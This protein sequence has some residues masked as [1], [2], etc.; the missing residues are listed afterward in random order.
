MGG[1]KETPRQ[2]M[3]GMMYL[4]LTALLALNVS[5]EVLEAFGNI[6][7][8]LDETIKVS[9]VK[10]ADLYT[11]ISQRVSSAGDD[12]NAKLVGEKMVQVKAIAKELDEHLD[13]LKK[14]MVETDANQ[15][16]DQYLKGTDEY[17]A[18]H[19]ENQKNIDVPTRLLVEKG[20]KPQN[21]GEILMEKINTT[22]K[23]LVDLFDGLSITTPAFKEDLDNRLTLK[24][25]DYPD[26]TEVA[27]KDWEYK[28]FNGIPCGAAIALLTKYQNDLKNAESEVLKTMLEAISAGKMEIKDFVPVV[29]VR[30][31]ALAVG[32]KLEAE[33]FLAAQIGG[34][35]PV[36]SVNGKEIEVDPLT[37]RGAYT[38]MAD[39]QGSKSLPVN[40]SVKNTKT[41][42]TKPYETVLE[43]DVFKAPAIISADKMNVVYQGLDNPISISVP[44][45][46]PSQISASMSPASVGELVK[47]S[48]GK[49]VAKIKGR[50]RNGVNINVSVKMPD[51]STKS[52]GSQNFRTLKVPSPTASLNGNQG[53]NMSTGALQAVKVVSVTLE[54]FVFE[55][56]RYKVVGF[57][58][59]YRPAR[60]NLIK[61][62]ENSQ[63][64]P[65]Q[66]RAA[67]SNAKRGDLL[68]ISGIYASAPGLGKVPLAGSLVFNV[69]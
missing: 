29:K 39:V 68:I 11:M 55:G 14:Q 41:G 51:G 58:Y 53:P 46:E 45:F 64:I 3:I 7:S 56:I 63:N 66:L 52:M 48:P 50:E 36:I 30:K 24:A 62:T 47:E 18:G 10:N 44:G 5:A 9:E 54:N 65:N 20:T 57:D 27:K 61:G 8:G 23:K 38:A 37:G 33:I 69:Q 40:I 13:E 49:Y 60:G 15:T 28:T 16:Y 1:G 25:S 32:E 19:L 67:F 4:V 31:S 26:E 21:G 34:V 2:K 12:P 6:T 59:I 43:Y 17:S 22:R 42:E 35:V